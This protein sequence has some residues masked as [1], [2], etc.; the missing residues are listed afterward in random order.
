MGAARLTDV[1]GT[2]YF[3]VDDGTHG[4]ELWGSDGT[5]AGTV[6]VRDLNPG[7]KGSRP[8]SITDLGGTVFFSADTPATGRELWSLQTNPQTNGMG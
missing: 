8:W 4:W 2:L 1:G 3:R 5:K 7:Q 6:M